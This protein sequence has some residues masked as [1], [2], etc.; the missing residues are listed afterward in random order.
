MVLSLSKLQ[1]LV[2]DRE[3]CHAV[4]SP[5]GWVMVWTPRVFTP[6]G[7]FQ[8]HCCCGEPMLTYTPIRGPSTLGGGFVS[9]SCGVTA[10]LFWVF[11]NAKFCLCP[12]RLES[13]FPSILWKAYHQI[14]LDF[15]ARFPGIP[16]PFVG[17]P[18]WEAWHGVQ[19]LH[20]S[21][22]NSLA[23]FSPVY[24]SL[25]QGIWDL[26][27]SWLHTF[28]HFTLASLYLNVDISF[29]RVPASTCQWLFNR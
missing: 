25:T 8:C 20:N 18:G 19:N 27:L 12:P 15:K 1:E 4:C 3:A 29:W 23:S 22:R 10:L 2:I 24:G 26:I 11:M 7:T 13:L 6:R 14:P 9:V 28:C 16:S 5:W 17:S 21:T